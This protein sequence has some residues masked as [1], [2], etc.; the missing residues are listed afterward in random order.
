M[1]KQSILVTVDNVIFTVEDNTLKVLL[2]QRAVEPFKGN[3]ALP[4]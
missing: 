3:W 4:G 1:I 2:I